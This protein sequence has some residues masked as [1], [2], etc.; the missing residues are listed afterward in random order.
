MF[1]I[2]I[3]RGKTLRVEYGAM[4]YMDSSL[5]MKTKL[6]GAMGRALTGEGLFISEFSA[7]NSDAEIGVAPPTPGDVDHV[8][9]ENE[10]IYLQSAAFV[11]S[12]PEITVDFKFE[13][14]DGFFSGEG[15]FLITCRGTGDLWFNTFGGIIEIDVTDEYVVDTGHIV[16]FTDTLSYRV[17][18]V[19][20]LKSLFLSGEGLIC[21]FSGSGKVWIQTRKGPA[22]VKRADSYRKVQS[23]KD[24]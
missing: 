8:Y 12:S 4:A 20:G 19:G 2:T 23:K 13:G 21:R 17:E 5:T 15:F 11:A 24:D 9:L 7:A 18:P 16:A 22:F 14:F 6:G 1:N 10:G 3:P